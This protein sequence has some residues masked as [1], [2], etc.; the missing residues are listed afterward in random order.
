M[1]AKFVPCSSSMSSGTLKSITVVRPAALPMMKLSCPSPPNST[2]WPPPSSRVSPPPPP[3]SVLVP[4]LPR[5]VSAC[6]LPM[7]KGVPPART[8]VSMLSRR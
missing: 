5:M 1:E 4:A 7:Q 8:S 2:S 3:A 6:A